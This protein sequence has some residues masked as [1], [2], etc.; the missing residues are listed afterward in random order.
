MEELPLPGNRHGRIYSLVMLVLLHTPKADIY[1]RTTRVFQLVFLGRFWF[2]RPQMG[3]Q[4]KC[5]VKCRYPFLYQL[6]PARV[7]QKLLSNMYVSCEFEQ[8]QVF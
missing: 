1:D 7:L 6:C 3:S 8:I 5:R 4:Q 2:N